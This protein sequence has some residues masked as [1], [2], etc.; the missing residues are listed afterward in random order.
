[1]YY[2]TLL[3]LPTYSLTDCPFEV[4]RLAAVHVAR[5]TVSELVVVAGKEWMNGTE[6]E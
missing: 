6:L 2:L 5:A 3:T 1:M 4:G